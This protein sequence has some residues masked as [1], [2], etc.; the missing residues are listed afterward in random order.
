[1]LIVRSSGG[2]VGQRRRSD[3]RARVLRIWPQAAR[4]RCGRKRW[5]RTPCYAMQIAWH[6]ACHAVASFTEA[7]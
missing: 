2:M 3:A 6:A 1:M 7:T 4:T 5:R